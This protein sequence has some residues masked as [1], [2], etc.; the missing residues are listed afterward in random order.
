LHRV[1][2]PQRSVGKSPGPRCG[3]LSIEASLNSRI[4]QVRDVARSQ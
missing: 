1:R 3:V 2:A 4:A